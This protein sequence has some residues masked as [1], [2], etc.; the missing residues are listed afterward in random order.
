MSEKGLRHISEVVEEIVKE[1]SKGRVSAS[2][3]NS[4]ERISHATVGGKADIDT[5][6][7]VVAN[8]HSPA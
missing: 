6:I 3:A 5:P 4:P 7:K 1:V 2:I 8:A